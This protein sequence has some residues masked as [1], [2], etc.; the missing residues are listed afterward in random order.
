MSSAAEHEGDRD[1]RSP[2]LRP[3][4]DTHRPGHKRA[5]SSI[6]I[7][8]V[9]SERSILYTLIAIVVVVSFGAYLTIIPSI[10][11]MEDILCHQY[12][13]SIVGP[14]HIGLQEKI[15]EE[16]CKGDKIQRDLSFIIGISDMMEAAPSRFHPWDIFGSQL[17]K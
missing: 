17:G 12:Y 2:L 14:G 13:D 11:L 5:R 16:L 10:R 1:E 8:I 7:P 9:H 15:D 6:H 4:P 3:P